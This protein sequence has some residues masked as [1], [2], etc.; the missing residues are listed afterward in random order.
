MWRV[1]ALIGV[2]LHRTS[3]CLCVEVQSQYLVGQKGV[4]RGV[5][6]GGGLVCVCIR[7]TGRTCVPSVCISL[8]KRNYL[9]G[10]AP[11]RLVNGGEAARG[12]RE[13]AEEME[14]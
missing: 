3:V 2:F 4:E 7:V 9:R 12:L 14:G 1:R 11:C 13:W 8:C 10:T 6:G 5:G